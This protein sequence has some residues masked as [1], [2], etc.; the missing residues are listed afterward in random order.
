MR[1]YGLIGRHLS[2]SFSKE[3]FTRKFATEGIEAQY[4]LYEL[5]D[6]TELNALIES[7]ESLCGLNVTI[8]Y[9]E[10][11]L[12][13]LDS[14]SEE[15]EA[16]GAVNCIAIKGG[17]R[18]GYNTDIIGIEATLDRLNIAPSHRAIIL[19]TGGAAKAVEYVLRRRQIEYLAVSRSVER[20]NIT[21][22]NLSPDDIASHHLIINTTPLGMYPNVETLPQIDYAAITPQHSVFDLVYNPDPTL[23]MQRAAEQGATVVGGKLMLYAQAEASWQIWNRQP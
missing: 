1:R 13:Y 12:P 17:R 5:R 7:E 21:Y 11:V 10:S 2:H 23:F 6:I 14:L 4:A 20:G 19:G 9:K 18:K 15:A 8:P 22:D 3:Y 16:V